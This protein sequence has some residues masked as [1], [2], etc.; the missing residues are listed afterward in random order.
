MADC[1]QQPQTVVLPLRLDTTVFSGIAPPQ[2]LL[3]AM[4]QAKAEPR[5]KPSNINTSALD[6]KLRTEGRTSAPATPLE[7]PSSARFPARPGTVQSAQPPLYGDAPPSY[8]DAVASSLPPLDAPR[9]DYAPPPAGEDVVLGGDEKKG[10]GG[11]R[12]S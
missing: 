6:E 12:D 11:R 9:P 3:E 4:A 10:F 2:G 7:G 1:A 8:E 5:P